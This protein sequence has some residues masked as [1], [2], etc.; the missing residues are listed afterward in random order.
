MSISL[1]N[2]VTIQV[3]KIE[4]PAS[5]VKFDENSEAM[6]REDTLPVSAQQ[7]L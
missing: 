6:E 5:G 7:S 3:P 2:G 4:G 1:G